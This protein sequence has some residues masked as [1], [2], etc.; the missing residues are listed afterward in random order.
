[1]VKMIQRLVALVEIKCFNMAKTVIR[2][3]VMPSM[4]W[5][6]SEGNQLYLIK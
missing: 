1:M 5:D 3:P 6:L 2:R 4:N